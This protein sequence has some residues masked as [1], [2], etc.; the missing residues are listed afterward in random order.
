MAEQNN[1]VIRAKRADFNALAEKFQI[2]PVVARILVNRDI[3][4]SKF[5]MFLHPDLNKMYDPFLM[6]GM[7]QA[8]R[9]ICHDIEEGHTIRI[10]SDYDVDG[11]MSNYILYKGLRR[12]GAD[13][14]YVIPHRIKDGYGINRDIIEKSIEDGIHTIITCDNGIAANDALTGAKEAGLTVVITD[15]HQVPFI[16]DNDRKQYI[17]PPADAILNPKQ[18]SCQYPF[19]DLCG[20]GVAYK[21]VE[22]LYAKRDIPHEEIYQFLEC[23]AIAVICDVVSLT[24]ENRIFAVHGLAQ[25]NHTN[26]KGL[27]ALIAATQLSDVTIGSHHVGFRLGPCINASGRLDSATLSMDLL[28]EEDTETAIAKAQTLSSINEERRAMTEEGLKQAGE[29]LQSVPEMKIF[30]IYLPDCHESLAG[31]IA[32]RIRDSYGHP[33]LVVVDS[34]TPGMLKGSGRSIEEFPMFEALQKCSDLLTQFG[35][36]A[37]AAGFSLDKDNLEA[38]TAR[39]NEVCELEENAFIPKV[40]IDVPMPISYVTEEL[41]AE[42]EEL[43]P[44]GKG[45]EKPLFAQ[46]NLNVLSAKIMGKERNVVK[47]TLENEEGWIQEG[48]YFDAPEFSENIIEWFGQDEYD[49]MLHGWLNNVVLNVVYYPVLN[50]FNGNKNIQLQIKR[51]AM[52]TVREVL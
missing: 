12:I 11:V 32:G 35:G 18:E 37:M 48:I 50:E 52:A 22:A 46:K 49:K 43:A 39:I 40:R 23:V 10:V 19:D 8:V 28:L 33:A 25:L 9:V 15:H 38:F 44:F 21:L 45:N 51:Y 47:V 16:M 41:I 27:R 6:D 26:N 4:E 17:L 34:D 5:D 30:V 2:N 24:D 42:L 13:V 36:H 29:Y 31:I 20:A 3:D 1:W 7:N 14:D